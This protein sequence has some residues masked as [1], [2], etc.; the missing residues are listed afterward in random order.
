[1]QRHELLNAIIKK[2]Q[3]LGRN[4]YHIAVSRKKK[5]HLGMFS[6]EEASDEKLEAFLAHLENA[7]WLASVGRMG[8]KQLELI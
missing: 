7:R 2:E 4:P 3:E 8:K 5:E 6:L 1:M